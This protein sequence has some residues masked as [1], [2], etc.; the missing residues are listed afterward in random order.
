MT[1]FTPLIPLPR[2]TDNKTTAGDTTVSHLETML[3]TSSSLDSSASFLV[4]DRPYE[5]YDSVRSEWIAV[6]ALLFLW[7]LTLLARQIAMFADMKARR[8]QEEEERDEYEPLLNP[9]QKS[10][11]GE[12]APRFDRAADALRITLLMLLSATIFVSIPMPYT[13]QIREPNRPGSPIPH[14]PQCTVCFT[15]GTTRG[16]SIISWV[17]TALSLLWFVIEL[18]VVENASTAI[19]RILVSLASFPLIATIFAIGFNEWAK[20]NA[21][22]NKSCN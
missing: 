22:A 3:T 12:W 19:A 17:F 18:A 4:H 6:T 7:L 16:T 8:R 14:E 21:R 5:H 11:P 1:V 10:K 20:I 15:N 9:R 2:R 13:C